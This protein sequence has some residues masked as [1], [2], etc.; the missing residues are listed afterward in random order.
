VSHAGRARLRGIAGQ[1]TTPLARLP[2][3]E[4]D[5]VADVELILVEVGDADRVAA[6][7][8]AAIAAVAPP[9]TLA[10]CAGTFAVVG[11]RAAVAAAAAGAPELRLPAV[12]AGAG[13]ERGDVRIA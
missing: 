8:A 4:R 11:Q 13:A 1:T 7:P 5:A 10:A 9:A 2:E 3:L 6:A 12:A